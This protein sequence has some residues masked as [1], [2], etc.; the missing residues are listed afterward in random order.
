ME[1]RLIN[2]LFNLAKEPATA[3]R[4]YPHD[5]GS[6]DPAAFIQ[7][8]RVLES[9]EAQGYLKLS[10]YELDKGGARVELTDA[11]RAWASGLTHSP[12]P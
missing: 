2:F 6:L 4:Y 12:H 1:R 11:G 3:K 5:I 8:L 9:L 10:S 7:D